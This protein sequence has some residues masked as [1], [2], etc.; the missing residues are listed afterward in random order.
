MLT[1]SI[2]KRMYI[3][4]LFFIA[5]IF[6]CVLGSM[7]VITIS[8]MRSTAALSLVFVPPILQFVFAFKFTNLSLIKKIILS[9]VISIIMYFVSLAL[10]E[11]NQFKIGIDQY[12]YFDFLIIYS[13]LSVL[14]WEVNYKVNVKSSK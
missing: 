1:M 2:K 7:L 3:Y 10:I 5:I 11:F 13:L 14:L 9:M 12:G 8:G 6:F 4:L